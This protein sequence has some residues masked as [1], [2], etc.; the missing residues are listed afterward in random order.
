MNQNSNID[1]EAIRREQEIYTYA[2]KDIETLINYLKLLLRA[3][4]EASEYF[5]EAKYNIDLSN[6]MEAGDKVEMLQNI[7]QNVKYYFE[8]IDDQIKRVLNFKVDNN[9]HRY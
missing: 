2:E 6:P 5:L 4:K 1:H 7:E 9:G 8:H 3:K